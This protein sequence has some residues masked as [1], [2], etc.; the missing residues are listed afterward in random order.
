M[1]EDFDV[2]NNYVLRIGLKVEN[3]F[4][5]GFENSFVWKKFFYFFPLPLPLPRPR[6]V[7]VD[8]AAGSSYTGRQIANATVV[9]RSYRFDFSTAEQTRESTRRKMEYN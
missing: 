8:E 1:N 3:S 2:E 5:V 7:L 9:R 6:S 4:R